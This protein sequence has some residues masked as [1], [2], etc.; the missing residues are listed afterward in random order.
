[1]KRFTF[2]WLALAFILCLVWSVSIKDIG[3]IVLTGFAF[4]YCLYRQF[5]YTN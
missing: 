4:V 3:M 5:K 1:M 2:L